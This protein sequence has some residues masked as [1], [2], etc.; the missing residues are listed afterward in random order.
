MEISQ[1]LLQHEN[2]AHELKNYIKEIQNW[3]HDNGLNEQIKWDFLKR[4]IRKFSNVFSKSLK[5]EKYQKIQNLEN[6]IK[7]LEIKLF[8]NKNMYNTV[9]E[10]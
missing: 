9:K 7:V 5:K 2:F 10:D 4:N 8:R 1:L 6:K 3:D